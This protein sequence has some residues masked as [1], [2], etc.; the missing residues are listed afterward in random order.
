MALNGP[1]Q[2]GKTTLA[3]Y[4]AGA[5]YTY[6]TLDDAT[7][8]EAAKTDPTGFVRGLDRAVIDEIQR[9]PDLM[10]ALKKAVDDDRRPGRFLITGS[11]NLLTVATT[12]ESLTGRME[13]VALLPL[14]Q[15]E[16]RDQSSA[17]FLATAF[18]GA[19]P[20][21]GR[22]L[23]GT[24]LVDT[25]LT[26]GY[27]GVLE[28]QTPQRRR[29]WCTSYIEA[30]AERDV[31]D[32]SALHK[33]GE[34]PNLVREA[35]R[36]AAQLLNAQS[37]ASDLRLTSRTVESY[38]GVLEQ[39]FLVKR[40]EPW[41]RNDLSRL[42]KTP[43]LHFVDSALLA[44]MSAVTSERISADRSR[45]GAVL[46]TFVFAE[47]Q[48]LATFHDEALRFSFYRDKDQLEV[49]F[50]LEND[51]GQMIGIEVKAAA[52]VTAAD[53]KGLRKLAELNAKTFRSGLVLYDGDTVI[54]FGENL[55]AAPLSSLWSP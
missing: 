3:K 23:T 11:A 35:A 55:Y 42:I 44:A 29:A 50:V 17:S 54:P 9:A 12:K 52:T 20:A 30:I 21:I 32:I 4:V 19:A 15:A 13:L 18:E 25:V 8:L 14:A 26:G 46:E 2:S 38:L 22:P 53:F 48:R 37:I 28:R 33:P 40:L 24:D 49:D 16:I 51:A 5:E 34:I 1:R 43:K 27:P 41:H 10:L 7:V 31:R 6:L 47:L 45:F 36:H 39:L